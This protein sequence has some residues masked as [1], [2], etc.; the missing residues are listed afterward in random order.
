[1]TPSLGSINFLEQLTGLRETFYLLDYQFILKGF[2]S[3]KARGKRC[4]EQGGEKG[5]GASMPS[6][7]SPLSR[8]LHVDTN[9][10]ALRTLSF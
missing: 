4:I 3:G 6:L 2:K 5:G 9:L 10:E 8:H 1:M 7:G